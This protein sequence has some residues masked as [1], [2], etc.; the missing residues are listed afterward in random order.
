MKMENKDNHTIMRSDIVEIEEDSLFDDLQALWD[1]QTALIDR[2][3][4]QSD[5]TLKESTPKGPTPCAPLR[6]RMLAAYVVLTVI[7]S[8]AA[9]YWGILIPSLAYTSIALV[10]SLVIELIYILLAAECLYHT[11]GLIIFDPARVGILRMSRHLRRSHLLPHYSPTPLHHPQSTQVI[12]NHGPYA[13][14]LQHQIIGEIPVQRMHRAAAASIAA[15]I[16]LTIV[17]CTITGTDGILITQNHPG[18][19]ASIETVNHFISQL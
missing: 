15:V 13:T 17:S 4:A 10:V 2:L 16:A 6:L 1:E 8:A 5:A 11:V 18:R 19:A 12:R 14:S 3:L 7:T 9:V